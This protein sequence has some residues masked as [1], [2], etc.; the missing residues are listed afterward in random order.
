MV[1]M[2]LLGYALIGGLLLTILAIIFAFYISEWV[3]IVIAVLYFIG[4]FAMITFHSKRTKKLD[5]QM[6]FNLAL[7]IMN[8]N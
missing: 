6:I 4:L 2:W 8:I 5:K 1:Q 7:I 3:S